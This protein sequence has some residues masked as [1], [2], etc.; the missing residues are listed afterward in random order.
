MLFHPLGICGWPWSQKV[1]NQI[2]TKSVERKPQ[3]ITSMDPAGRFSIDSQKGSWLS[4][5][6]LMANSDKESQDGNRTCVKGRYQQRSQM[7]W[8]HL[9]LITLYT[10]AFLTAAGLWNYQDSR[11]LA[12]CMSI[13]M[14][15][16]KSNRTQVN[17]QYS[18]GF[19]S[20]KVSES[21]LRWQVRRYWPISRQATPW[22][23]Q[24]MAWSFREHQHMYQQRRTSK[25]KQNSN[26]A[27][28]WLWI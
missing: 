7:F 2:S 24:S 13:L 3:Q 4:S 27:V 23:W 11:Q 14:S 20:D 5:Q 9:L 22:A 10:F 12:Y 16:S 21:V 26:R 28:R 17:L 8:I 25:I 6:P 19:K 18:T 1:S 15:S